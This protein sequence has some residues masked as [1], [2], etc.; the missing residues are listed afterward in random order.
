MK[1]KKEERRKD[2]R[3]NGGKGREKLSGWREK[4]KDVMKEKNR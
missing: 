3:K 4:E 2:I 1:A